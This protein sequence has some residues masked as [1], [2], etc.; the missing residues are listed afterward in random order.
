MAEEFVTDLLE[1]AVP[2]MLENDPGWP[3]YAATYNVR[4]SYTPV[5][6][7]LPQ[8]DMQVARVVESAARHRLQVQARSGGHSYTSFSHG[9][10]NGAVV[11]DLR[12]L[13]DVKVL[14]FPDSDESGIARVGGGVRLGNLALRLYAQGKRALA[15]GTC[16]SVGIGGHFT[17]G[18][19]GHCS[20]A[21]G[22]AMDQIVAMDV[23]LAD[24]S[25][26]RAT[27]SENKDV[28]Y[29]MRG[30]A[31]S[32]GIAVNF[33][34]RTQPAPKKVIRWTFEFGDLLGETDVQGAV[35]TMLNLQKL[36]R[37]SSL[38]DRRFSF[39]VHLGNQRFGISG[40]YLGPLDHFTERIQ[41]ALLRCFSKA[42]QQ[43]NGQC[44]VLGWLK[45]LESQSGGEPL[46]TGS[47]YDG[48]SNFF[49]KSVMVPEPG[50]SADALTSY[51]S[52]IAKISASNPNQ[53][54]GEEI[55]WFAILD[56]Y[57]G[58]DSQI[59]N[60]VRHSDAA[61]PHRS[62]LW[63]A[64]HYGFVDNS[65]KFPAAGF[66]LVEGLNEAM[67]RHMGGRY[68]AYINYTDSSLSREQSQALYYGDV[69]LQ[70][71]RAIKQMLDPGNV[72]AHPQ[73]IA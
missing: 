65:Q 55:G 28:F 22:L 53:E 60:I 54:I 36:V 47:A 8:T 42:P 14:G 13:Q 37:D 33:Y 30:A 63:V 56:L 43:N 62:S 16:P 9:G 7:V 41:P 69:H 15:H 46:A 3:A 44:E 40:I 10:R 34:L 11:I 6:I 4:L 35:C 31:D 70:R 27:E 1:E 20:R 26:V 66:G 50:L 57:G 17:H 19:Y 67:V 45:T 23:V 68:A 49:A 12:A 51:F 71:L 38:I 61:F 52:F 32:F 5:A 24:G 58:A 73:S 18:G 25:L 2:V 64:Q 59:N 29:A 39:G 48:H 21:W 72:F